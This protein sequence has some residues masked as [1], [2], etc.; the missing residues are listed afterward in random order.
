MNRVE[1]VAEA[2]AHHIAERYYSLEGGDPGD[3]HVLELI[4]GGWSVYYSDRYDRT[5]EQFYETEDEACRELLRRLLESQLQRENR[6][7][8]QSERAAP[9]THGR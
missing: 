6:L 3:T 7:K 9:N 8:S 2:T 4:P 5:H 1:L